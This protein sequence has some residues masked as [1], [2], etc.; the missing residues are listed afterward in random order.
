MYIPFTFHPVTLILSYIIL[1]YQ[2][3]FI[4]L[5]YI[6]L[7]CIRG[8]QWFQ[9]FQHVSTFS[10]QPVQQGAMCSGFQDEC[11]HIVSHP[12]LKVRG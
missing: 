8:F 3:V 11:C 4:P 5:W 9:V 10:V 2:L 12:H 7:W 6:P 1:I